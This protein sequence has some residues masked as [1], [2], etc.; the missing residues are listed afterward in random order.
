MFIKTFKVRKPGF[1]LLAAGA[2]ILA[3]IVIMIV[4]TGGKNQEYTMKNEKD[5]QSFL[6]EMGWEVSAEY[7]ECKVVII[8]SEF[9]D[10]YKEYNSMQKEQGFDL[11]KYKGK[12]VEIFTYEVKNYPEHK[13]NMVCNIMIYEGVLIGGDVSCIEV[14]GF[15]QGLKCST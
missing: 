8:P 12:T 11:A 1:V 13:K 3:I 9:N 10:V 5:R 14:D 4:L 15:M 2:V 7:L 6:S